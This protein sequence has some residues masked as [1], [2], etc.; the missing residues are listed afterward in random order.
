MCAGRDPSLLSGDLRLLANGPE[1]FLLDTE[2]SIADKNLFTDVDL[3][4]V[5]ML[6]TRGFRVHSWRWYKT[7]QQTPNRRDKLFQCISFVY[8]PTYTFDIGT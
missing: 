5:I 8:F 3:A 1:F 2:F 7:R 4:S 6:K